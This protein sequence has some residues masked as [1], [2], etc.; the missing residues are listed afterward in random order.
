M[1]KKVMFFSQ[2]H[3]TTTMSYTHTH[4]HA[5]MQLLYIPLHE[6][7]EAPR[8]GSLIPFWQ[9]ENFRRKRYNPL[10]TFYLQHH[11]YVWVCDIYIPLK[12]SGVSSLYVAKKI[13]GN[14]FFWKT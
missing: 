11:Y 12:T 14:K 13:L 2:L 9:T 6:V 5:H 10:R 1:M 8:E 3:S 4:M 7:A